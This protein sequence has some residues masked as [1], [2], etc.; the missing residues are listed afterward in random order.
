MRP[1]VR[2]ARSGLKEI[3][4]VLSLTMDQQKG[5]YGLPG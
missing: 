3:N 4:L 1:F 2:L 5:L